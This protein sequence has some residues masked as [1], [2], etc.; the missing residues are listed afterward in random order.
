MTEPLTADASP[1]SPLARVLSLFTDVRS[2]EGV[3][4]LLLAFTL[5]TSLVG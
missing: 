5:F 3:T 2:G 4:A 1:K